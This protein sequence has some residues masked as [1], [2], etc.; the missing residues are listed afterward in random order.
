M[1]VLLQLVTERF[2][3]ISA[4]I[5]FS[6]RSAVSHAEFV[7]PATGSTFGARC[8]GVKWR[9][10][11]ASQRYTRVLRFSAPAIDQA[12]KWGPHPS[13]E[14][15]RLFRHRRHCA[16]S[17]LARL[18]PVVLL[19]TD[20]RSLRGCWLAP[21]QPLRKCLAHHPSRFTPLHEPRRRLRN[22]HS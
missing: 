8:T 7:D 19:R 10:A 2:D 13:R 18:T 5:R 1:N 9:S 3:P 22:I 6:T 4:A 20:R 15:L 21:P 11:H 16:R 12:F 17:Q 14:A